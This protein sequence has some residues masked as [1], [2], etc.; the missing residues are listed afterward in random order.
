MRRSLACTMLLIAGFAGVAHAH[1]ADDPIALARA[2]TAA[3]EARRFG[4]ALAAFTKAADMRPNDASLC[5]GAGV[6][7][8]MLGKNEEAQAR[9]ECAL[10]RNPAFVP[11]AMWLADLHYRAGRLADAISIYETAQ[12]RSAKPRDLQPQLD[13]WRKELALQNRLR[14]ARSE[15][16]V[17]LFEAA[18]DEPLAA[19][20]IKR[21][22]RAY[23]RIVATVGVSPAQR[24][25]TVIY[26]RDQ[27]NDIT[28]LA[29]WSAAAYDGRIRVPV[30]ETTKASEL[31]RILSHEFVHALVSQLGGRTVPAWINEGLA[32]VLEPAGSGD[33]EAAL[34][35]TGE[36]RTLS[37]LPDSFVGLSQHDAELAY[38]S[39]ARAVRRLIERRGI[40]A[41]VALLEDL[42]QGAPF[43]RAFRQRLAMR[44]EDFSASVVRDSF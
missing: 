5:F 27:F 14:D 10:A 23:R 32:T 44:Y 15:H 30:D 1:A 11:A 19:D 16:F 24:I 17:V 13:L 38:A 31:D 28:R 36:R 20:V 4:D 37:Q 25:T 39:S 6:A 34:A 7:A 41:L 43:S 35:R 3:I 8:F 2:G 26:T 21:L 42:G 12:Q 40:D 22:E 33:V 29:E 9:F 18:V